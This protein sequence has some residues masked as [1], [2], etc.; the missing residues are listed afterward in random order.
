M[1]FNLELL[2]T[3]INNNN[4][5]DKLI[6]ALY[7]STN[8]L[9]INGV[10]YESKRLRLSS[11]MVNLSQERGIPA[12]PFDEGKPKWNM[13]IHNATD[14]EYET[15]KREHDDRLAHVR[16]REEEEREKDRRRIE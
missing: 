5:R 13:H 2:F 11:V 1:L 15:K 12:G 16:M 4:N 10:M 14:E 7:E 3:L 9:C 8:F 6:S